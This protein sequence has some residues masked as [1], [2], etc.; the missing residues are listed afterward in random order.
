MNLG[1]KFK[2]VVRTCF[3]L[4]VVISGC[5]TAK[6]AIEMGTGS[7]PQSLTDTVVSM[8]GFRHAILI[9]IP[10][11]NNRYLGGVI[12]DLNRFD[13]ANLP[14]LYQAQNRCQTVEVLTS[15]TDVTVEETLIVRADGTMAVLGSPSLSLENALLVNIKMRVT[16]KT[17]ATKTDGCPNG[18][19][20]ITQLLWGE[21]YYRYLRVIGANAQMPVPF[22]WTTFV[23]QARASGSVGH[24]RELKIPGGYFIALVKSTSP[25]STPAGQAEG[26]VNPWI[27]PPSVGAVDKAV[28]GRVASKEWVSCSG[29]PWCQIANRALDACFEDN[30]SHS[31]ADYEKTLADLGFINNVMAIPV[32]RL[33]MWNAKRQS[34]N[35]FGNGTIETYKFFYESPAFGAALGAGNG[36]GALTVV[37]PVL[38]HPGLVAVPIALAGAGTTVAL[39][40]PQCAKEDKAIRKICE[41]KMEATR[42]FGIRQETLPAYFYDPK[43][44]HEVLK[45]MTR[46]DLVEPWCQEI[47]YGDQQKKIVSEHFLFGIGDKNHVYFKLDPG[48][49]VLLVGIAQEP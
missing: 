9:P 49:N 15:P 38:I 42:A 21:G 46:A 47:D 30:H 8:F 13:P 5:A 17:E 23:V 4:A 48:L 20:R 34:T 25:A 27:A 22:D 18:Q 33:T 3:A 2:P 44:A 19:G 29:D 39:T 6:P 31:P 35:P 7:V 45:R 43:T 32:G 41:I 1:L 12:P 14:D 26:V 28:A 16:Q 11:T 40:V 37:M 24:E 36:F 10:A